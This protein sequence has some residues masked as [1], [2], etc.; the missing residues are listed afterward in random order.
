MCSALL[1]P[2]R[3]RAILSSARTTTTVQ[4]MIRSDGH[5]SAV[6][7]DRPFWVP[8]GLSA[9]V[10]GLFGGSTRCHDGS[11]M[12][13]VDPWSLSWWWEWRRP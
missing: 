1:V 2:C 7:S 11:R 9:T 12:C 6:D 5:R 13:C 10:I 3:S 8:T 4:L